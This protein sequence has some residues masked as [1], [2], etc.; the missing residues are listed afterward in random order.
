[1]ML[2]AVPSMLSVAVIIDMSMIDGGSIIVEN[3]A[4]TPARPSWVIANA[5]INFLFNVMQP[6]PL[7][8]VM[9]SIIFS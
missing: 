8:S 5:F 4:S 1:M 6:L 7:V 9:A 2:I 3:N